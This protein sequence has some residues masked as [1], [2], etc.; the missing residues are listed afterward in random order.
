[1]NNTALS[2]LLA[3]GF[4]Q[5]HPSGVAFGADVALPALK[6]TTPAEANPWFARIGVVGVIYDSS[7]TIAT[8]G[9][10]IPG[11][12][13]TVSN[14]VTVSFDLG[15][16]I[17]RDIALSVMGGV[18]AKPTATGEGT[19]AALGELGK[20]LY[21]PA[22]FTGYYR[23][24]N[25]GGIRPYAG[26]GAA[27]AIVFKNYD[28]AVMQLR[29][30]NGWGFVLQAGAEYKLNNKFDLFVDYKK[31]WI[32]LDADGLISGAP[33]VTARVKL[34]PSIVSAGIKFRFP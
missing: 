27:Y 12:T 20:V 5:A 31:I 30:H 25:W 15:Y 11:A 23:F 1:M 26:L 3:A 13:A 10:T 28:A 24:P 2:I 9:Q 14:N 32:S 29:V 7:A 16:D 17:T 19:V 21:G 22:T 33:P 4:L 18:P 34:D 8:N 6:N